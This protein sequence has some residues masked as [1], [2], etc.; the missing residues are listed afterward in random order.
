MSFDPALHVPFLV[1]L[2]LTLLGDGVRPGRG[3]F[4]ALLA[5]GA[6][7]YGAGADRL[8]GLAVALAV[9]GGSTLW[10]R[11]R[12]GV[13]RRG[14]VAQG[15]VLVGSLGALAAGLAGRFANA[16]GGH[17]VE[18]IGTPLVGD[19]PSSWIFVGL[20][21]PLA[22]PGALGGAT[23]GMDLAGQR[24]EGEGNQATSLVLAAAGTLL[25]LT[26]AVALFRTFT[27]SAPLAAVGTLAALG[28]LLEAVA[29]SGLRRAAGLRALVAGSIGLQVIALAEA[30]G[31]GE[32][33]F[34]LGMTA[35]ALGLAGTLV[36][37]AQLGAAPPG[38][39]PT[40]LRAA[41]VGAVLAAVSLASIGALPL[42]LGF[43]A[44]ARTL[45][46]TSGDLPQEALLAAALQG[47][48]FALCVLPLLASVLRAPAP[49]AGEG[50]GARAALGLA[51]AATVGLGAAPEAALAWLAP[52][53]RTASSIFPTAIGQLSMLAASAAFALLVWRRVGPAVTAATE[54]PEEGGPTA[55][56]VGYPPPP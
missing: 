15:A 55:P 13:P 25:P 43:A 26:L 27:G 4:A 47:P 29:R 23:A 48:L 38:G 33:A 8:E 18:W 11:W 32:G 50:L 56:P 7:A 44:R 17:A 34:H 28:A 49:R 12:H 37:V 9:L 3:D 41:P 51:A 45:G 14:L 35:L 2:V 16:G 52:G 24:P 40:V 19:G 39:G 36:A 31:P 53:A 30:S 42:T 6:A 54:A 10:L 46:I 20:A 21:A 5:F 22:V 1:V